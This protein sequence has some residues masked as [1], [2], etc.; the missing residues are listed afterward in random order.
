MMHRRILSSMKPLF[1]M[2]RVKDIETLSWS[3]P[4]PPQNMLGLTLFNLP[5]VAFRAGGHQGGKVHWGGAKIKK[6]AKN[7]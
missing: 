5:L 7:G 4:L 2:L 6:N 3:Y 1:L